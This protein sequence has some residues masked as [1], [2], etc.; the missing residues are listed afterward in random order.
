MTNKEIVAVNNAAKEQCH[1]FERDFPGT[2]AWMTD[3]EYGPQI[4]AD[5]G[6]EYGRGLV[7]YFQGPADNFN[8]FANAFAYGWAAHKELS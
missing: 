2:R 3:S 5:N 1:T 4:Q 6:K 7:I 8:A